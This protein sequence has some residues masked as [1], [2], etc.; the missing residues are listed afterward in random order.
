MTIGRPV[1]VVVTILPGRIMRMRRRFGSCVIVVM[2][3][4][5]R[6]IAH[7][8]GTLDRQV[9]QVDGD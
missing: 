3:M 7:F 4:S 2:V 1:L 5:R 8:V 9:D 6:A